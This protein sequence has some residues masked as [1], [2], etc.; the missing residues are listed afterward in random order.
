MAVGCLQ[1]WGSPGRIDIALAGE[2]WIYGQRS[3]ASDCLWRCNYCAL[4]AM[5]VL[6]SF[7][8]LFLG[9]SRRQD[10]WFRG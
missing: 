7:L 1:P 3:G 5:Y 10:D 2:Y 6:A 8:V 9:L 4:H